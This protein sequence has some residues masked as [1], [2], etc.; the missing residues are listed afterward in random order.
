[1]AKNS[2]TFTAGGE[3]PV[4]ETGSFFRV[5]EGDHPVT[6]RFLGANMD[7]SVELDPGIGVRVPGGWDYVLVKSAQAQTITYLAWDAEILDNRRSGQVVT[8]AQGDTLADNGATTVGDTATQL[9]GQATRK[10]LHFRN[11]G[12]N[13][14][15]LGGAGVTFAGGA[16]L[17]APGDE[18][19]EEAMAGAAW[20][21]ICASGASADVAVME[22]S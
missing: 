3:L 19:R 13:D 1:M 5:L 14:V 11:V 16:V 12:T 7:T 4:Y 8:V 18:W 15:V 2:L 10:G 6:V 21:G 20:Y 22:G 9:V 17:L